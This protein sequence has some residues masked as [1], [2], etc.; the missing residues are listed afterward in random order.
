MSRLDESAS[1]ARHLNK[2]RSAHPDLLHLAGSGN[3]D[4][5]NRG[6]SN[7]MAHEALQD[8]SATC[9]NGMRPL[10]RLSDGKIAN[11]PAGACPANG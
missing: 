3:H 10:A 5:I 2:L 4:P 11:P 7:P 1:P 8:P 9:G 6:T